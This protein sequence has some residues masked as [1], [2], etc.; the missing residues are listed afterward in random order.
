M[1]GKDTKPADPA[2][3]AP[4]PQYARVAG[5]HLP[6]AK[7]FVA[8]PF[9]ARALMAGKSGTETLHQRLHGKGPIVKWPAAK[10]A[11]ITHP[12]LAQ[13][14]TS[15]PTP[16]A[17]GTPVSTGENMSER[18][19]AERL[20]SDRGTSTFNPQIP[21]RVPDIPSP[22]AVKASEADLEG[23][24]L[25]VGR[26]VQLCGEIGGCERLV[27]EGKV[28]V[29]LKDVKTLEVGAQGVFK[30]NA[31]VDA[32]VI[33]GTFEGTLKVSGHLD[34]GPGA[35]VKGTVSYGTISVASGG[36]L[37]GTVESVESGAG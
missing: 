33:A 4:A 19:I 12:A 20:M 6:P 2:D 31:V 1:D 11:R 16:A 36:K 37:L 26:A 7:A 14:V 28:D 21:R 15:A 32:A 27:I 25:L 17:A 5:R 35:V 24:R 8:K 13:R 9:S 30:G 34:V 23:K 18:F 3:T 29:T 10:P 22:S